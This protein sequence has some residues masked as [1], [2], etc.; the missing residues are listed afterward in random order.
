MTGC[1][2]DAPWT[3]VEE[4]SRLWT[5]RDV[6]GPA[7]CGYHNNFLESA[8]LSW[9]SFSDLNEALHCA[10]C[11]CDSVLKRQG[12]G[13]GFVSTALNSGVP[14]G[15]VW[16]HALAGGDVLAEF[17]CQFLSGIGSEL[18]LSYD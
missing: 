14:H 18:P 11:Y 2:V 9:K 6:H 15:S 17:S 3:A 12:G 8:S 13:L 16:I 10:P 4:C 1:G 5:G 7:L